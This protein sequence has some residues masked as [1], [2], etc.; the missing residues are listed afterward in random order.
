MA[1]YTIQFLPG[2]QTITVAEGTNLLEAARNAGLTPNAPCG[3]K[4]TCGKC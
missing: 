2:G 1:E 4:G 3:G